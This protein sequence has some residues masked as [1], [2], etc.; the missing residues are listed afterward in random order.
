MLFVLGILPASAILDTNSNGMSDVWE[1][2]YNNGQLFPSTVPTT[3]PYGHQDDPDCDGWSN[4][5]EAV[6]GTDPFNANQPDG[7]TIP[8][9]VYTSAIYITDPYGD[10]EILLPETVA[11]TWSTIPGK[12]YTLLV[13]PDLQ[14][15]SWLPVDQPRIGNGLLMGNGITLTQPNNPIPPKLFW[16]VKIEDV[17]SDNDG[18]TNTEEYQLGT[19]PNNPQTLSGYDDLWLAV[20]F[21]DLLL[22]GEIDDIDTD[23]DGLTNAQEAFLGTNPNIPDNPGISQEQ[24]TNGDFSFP[25]IGDGLQG[26]SAWDYWAGVSGWT[27]VIGNHIE[28]QNIT[29]IEAGNQYVELKSDPV[30]YYGIKQQVGTRIGITYLLALDCRDRADVDPEYSNFDIRIDGETIRSINFSAP[31]TSTPPGGW[32]TV[33]VAFT[34]TSVITEISLVPVFDPTDTTGGLVDNVRLSPVAVEI[35]HTEKARDQKGNEIS[36]V[37]NP[38][39]DTLLRDEIADLKIKIAIINN[40]NWNLHIDLEPSDMQKQTLGARGEVQ[41]YDFGKVNNGVVTPLTASSQG[42]TQSG[43]YDIAL[44]NATGGEETFKIVVNRE[45][46]FK[47]HINTADNSLDFVSREFTV[48]KRIRKYATRE[49]TGQTQSNDFDTFFEDSVNWWNDWGIGNANGNYTFKDSGVRYTPEL[50]K[51]ISWKE[52]DLRPASAAAHGTNQ[53]DIMQVN[54]GTKPGSADMSGTRALADWN[55]R[56]P[57]F[58][59]EVL[60]EGVYEKRQL[61]LLESDPP[62][63]LHATDFSVRKMRYPKTGLASIG[64]YRESVKWAL[65]KLLYKQYY[66]GDDFFVLYRVKGAGD[67][68]FAEAKPELRSLSETVRHYGDITPDYPVHVF[69]MRDEGIGTRG[70]GDEYRWPRLTNDK[71][72]H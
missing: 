72:R 5:Q 53:A 27:G 6:A 21:T 64:S 46:A 25:Y 30:G 11:L 23:G 52:C 15:E 62:A 39:K 22:N 50:L 36:A 34:A 67:T 33:F 63:G 1:K 57:T 26:D 47:L 65:R 61:Y 66:L 4:E 2:L 28:F 69:R 51:A 8:E 14:S 49:T 17:D 16:K 60:I 9:I 18:L 48:T 7:I 42:V 19:N 29:P 32:S 38:G 40:A 37:V 41:M 20:N 58:E 24:I 12:Q 54:A 45:G 71:A 55:D 68:R 70:N 44:T 35:K 3:F 10:S 31:G 59:V 13:S 56:A 43:P